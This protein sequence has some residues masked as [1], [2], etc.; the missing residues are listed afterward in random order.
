[1]MEVTDNEKEDEDTGD[2]SDCGKSTKE[3]SGGNVD[4]INLT[5]CL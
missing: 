2:S 1:M 5:V 3:G 4:D